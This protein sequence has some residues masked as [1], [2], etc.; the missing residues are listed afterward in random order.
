MPEPTTAEIAD[1]IEAGRVALRDLRPALEAGAPWPLSERFDHADEAVWGPPEILAHLAEMVPYWTGE[2]ERV[3]DGAARG[4]EPVPFG[5]LA[6]DDV[7]TA[8]LGRDR[9]LPVA[10]LLSRID[11]DADRLEQRLR[12]LTEVGLDRRGLHPRRGE[13]SVRELL[14]RFVVDHLDE[15]LRQLR[16][17]LSRN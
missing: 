10:E 2:M 17:L 15:H 4:A 6:T 7:R 8:V 5:R 12:G 9:S 16:P 13:Q 1:R 3:L 14:E 11:A